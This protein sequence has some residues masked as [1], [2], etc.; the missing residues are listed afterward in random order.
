MVLFVI[1]Y[2][3]FTFQELK[4]FKRANK[5]VVSFLTEKKVLHP[6]NSF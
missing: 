6:L 3:C 2:L 1:M 5:K 4:H